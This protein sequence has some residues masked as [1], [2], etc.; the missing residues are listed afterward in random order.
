MDT[1]VSNIVSFHRPQHT[2]ATEREKTL[3][4]LKYRIAVATLD[5]LR[6][7]KE[8]TDREFEVGYAF[9]VKR[10]HQEETV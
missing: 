7:D 4:A 1:T 8:I 6:Q 3:N 10:F 2:Q 9:L 5:R